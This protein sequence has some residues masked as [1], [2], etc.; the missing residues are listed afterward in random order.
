M[1]DWTLN[2][3]SVGFYEYEVLGDEVILSATK[4]EFHQGSPEQATHIGVLK[5]VCLPA[6][7]RGRRVRFFAQLFTQ[8]TEGAGLWL[9]ASHNKWHITDGMYDR[10]VKGS[11]SW[12]DEQLVI[13]IP[14]DASKVSCGLWMIGAGKCGLRSAK[15]EMVDE[16]VPVTTDKFYD[17]VGPY[18]WVLRRM[19]DD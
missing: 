8:E 16:S 10:L 3:A 7:C 9:T 1:H 14:E 17:R 4:A 13:D 2:N 15:F 5:K 11:C 19:I 6:D 18:E 12:H